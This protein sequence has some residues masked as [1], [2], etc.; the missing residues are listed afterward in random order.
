M[1]TM[2]DG[3]E[4]M[5]ISCYWLGSR[6]RNEWIMPAQERSIL[7]S[8]RAFREYEK[9]KIKISTKTRVAAG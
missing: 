9:N 8:T 7:I 6:L 3:Y 1:D 4:L 5:V 2:D